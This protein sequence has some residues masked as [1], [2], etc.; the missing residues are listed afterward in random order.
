MP[1]SLLILRIGPVPVPLPVFLLWPIACL[2]WV[3]I[4]VAA[5][6]VL[7]SPRSIPGLRCA[8]ATLELLASSRGLRVDV[9]PHEGPQIQMILF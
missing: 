5:L 4:W 2:A 6:V 3:G 7:R 1:P 9:S 8:L